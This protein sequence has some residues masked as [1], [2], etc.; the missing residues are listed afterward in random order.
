MEGAE[1]SELAVL[2]AQAGM[3]DGEMTASGPEAMLA[4][5]EAEQAIV[6]ADQNIAS[7]ALILALSVPFLGR[8]YPSLLVVYTDEAQ[9]AVSATL[10]PVLTKY[11]INLGD[12]GGRW[13][14]E[15]AAVAVCGPIAIA[16]LEGIKADIAAREKH[17]PKAVASNEPR[18]VEKPDEM[19]T[20]G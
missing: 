1:N 17:V 3:I 15:I 9:G 11:G 20:L 14:E 16:T 6:E 10:G 7:V 8:L 19:V 18:Q 4:A 13:K 5:Q 12:M 2:A